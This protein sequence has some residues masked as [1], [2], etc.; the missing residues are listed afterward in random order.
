M[1][2]EEFKRRK[3]RLDRMVDRI[4]KSPRGSTIRMTYGMKPGEVEET[5]LLPFEDGRT[6]QQG[7]DL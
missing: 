5:R 7:G 6:L 1:S 3:E 4:S 2:A